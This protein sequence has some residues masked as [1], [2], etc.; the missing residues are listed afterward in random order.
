MI[1]PIYINAHGALD[2][3]VPIP[4]FFA[5]TEKESVWIDDQEYT[6]EEIVTY[7]DMLA[8]L[9]AHCKGRVV[10]LTDICYSGSLIT[11]ASDLKLSMD[12]YALFTATDRR[13]PSYAW[14]DEFNL[15]DMDRT[16]LLGKLID[17][18]DVMVPFSYGWFTN[19]LCDLL[20]AGYAEDENGV[21]TVSD[22]CN[23]IKDTLTAMTMRLKSKWEDKNRESLSLDSFS[24]LD[25]VFDG[26]DYWYERMT[27]LLKVP[28]VAT[29]L[30]DMNPLEALQQI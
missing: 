16:G 3:G 15:A 20:D 18:P 24:G 7:R 17:L 10:L 1:S 29:L 8:Y 5:E 21:V 23:Y 6:G 4:A 11:T 2:D 14:P 25:D 9:E 12:K 22:A 28:G 19:N 27:G 26:M 13:M 30:N